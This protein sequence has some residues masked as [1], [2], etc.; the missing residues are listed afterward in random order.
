MYRLV[1]GGEWKMARGSAE[2]ASQVTE[3]RAGSCRLSWNVPVVASFETTSCGE[4]PR[5]AVAV[6]TLDYLGRSVL[7]G[8][9]LTHL[10]VG[11]GRTTR[12]IQLFRPQPTSV[13]ARW[14]AWLKGCSYELKE[15]DRFLCEAN[16][17]HAVV[18]Q[19]AGKLL[20][21]CD[22]QLKGVARLGYHEVT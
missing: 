11:Q 1:S 21:S 3:C 12:T 20:F 4:W 9:G 15:F 2:G 17:R 14:V 18:A 10:P 22:T 16:D 6:Y 8:Y 7:A 5:L 13:L 19:V